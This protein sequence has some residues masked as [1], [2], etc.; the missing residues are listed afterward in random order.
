[1][2]K[3]VAHAPLVS[4]G[5]KRP[6][7]KVSV[8][9]VRER[10]FRYISADGAFFRENSLGGLTIEF[11]VTDVLVDAQDMALESVVGDKINYR[12]VQI[13][14]KAQIRSQIAVRLPAQT[15]V[16]LQNLLAQKMRIP[17]MNS[18]VQALPGPANKQR[19]KNK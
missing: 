11:Y 15:V 13:H 19:L 14:E 1:M 8:P 3:E 2:A 12:H 9:I 6:A 17:V 4:A 10:D 18:P 16:D 5:K 7:K